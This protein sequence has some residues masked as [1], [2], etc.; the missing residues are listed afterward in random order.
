M[1]D[2]DCAVGYTPCL[3]ADDDHDFE[4]DEA[5]VATGAAA[6]TVERR[7]N[8]QC[9]R[10][11]RI[12]PTTHITTHIEEHIMSDSTDAFQIN[13]SEQGCPVMHGPNSGH[14]AR[15]MT[16]NE[17]RRPNQLNLRMLASALAGIDPDGRRLRLRRSVQQRS[18]TPR[19]R[20]TSPH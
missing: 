18:T 6:P 17:H 13:D 3:T 9:E 15:G 19:S 11:P 16:A 5:E 4:I 1:F 2:I 20:P 8:P 7:T 14:T 12:Q 10:Q